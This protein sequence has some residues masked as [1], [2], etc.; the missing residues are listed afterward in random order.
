[1]LDSM[2]V[3]VA[4]V[5]G[6]P[7]ASWIRILVRTVARLWNLTVNLNHRCGNLFWTGLF[8]CVSTYSIS[9]MHDPTC[10][11]KLDSQGGTIE[12]ALSK[13]P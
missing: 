2:V 10:E 8:S 13:L 1:M 11:H 5:G 3:T 12:E 6:L 4:T 9:T 7:E